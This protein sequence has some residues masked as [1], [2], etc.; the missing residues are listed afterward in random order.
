MNIPIE[1]LQCV[2]TNIFELNV[3]IHVYYIA[4][5][6]NYIPNY[7]MQF[8]FNWYMSQ[9]CRWILLRDSGEEPINSE[10][11]ELG[12]QSEFDKIYGISW[13]IEKLLCS[14]KLDKSFMR[15]QFSTNV[16]FR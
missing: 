9:G 16:I 6:G 1:T 14:R 5:S 13:Q 15:F 7:Y 12:N 10:A 11:C 2:G 4:T 3:H 8:H